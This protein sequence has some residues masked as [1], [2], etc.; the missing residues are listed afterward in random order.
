MSL[1]K[2]HKVFLC[3]FEQKKKI[4]LLKNPVNTSKYHFLLQICFTC[5][6]FFV[7]TPTCTCLKEQKKIYTK[8]AAFAKFEVRAFGVSGGQRLKRLTSCKGCPGPST[9]RLAAGA[10]QSAEWHSGEWAP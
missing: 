3:P 10:A 7:A 1:Y 9:G 4:I 6:N 8:F 2:S 5:Q